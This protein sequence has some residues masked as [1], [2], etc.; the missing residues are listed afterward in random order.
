MRL[1]LRLSLF[2]LFIL[3]IVFAW[4]PWREHHRVFAGALAGSSSFQK[5]NPDS[6][7]Q[8]WNIQV[9]DSTDDV[10]QYTSLALDAVGNPHISYY[11]VTNQDLKY[12]RWSGD[13]WQIQ[14]VDST[15]NVGWYTSLALDSNS[16]PH[17]S[18]SDA[19]N[20]TL[21]YAYWT[22]SSWQIQTVDSVNGSTPTSLALDSS[23]RPHISYN[24]VSSFPS[25]NQL[26]YAVWTGSAW[27]LQTVDSNIGNL[28]SGS[29]IALDNSGNPH[30]SYEYSNFVQP[31]TFVRRLYYARW[32]GTSWQ[33]STVDSTGSVGDSCSI[34]VDSSGNP[35]ISY[36]DLSN[37][38]LK[39]ARWTG[40]SWLIQ[41]V[42]G[43]G[44]WPEGT[45]IAVDNGGTPHISFYDSE[46]SVLK[47]ARWTG[48]VWQIQTVDSVGNVGMYSSLTLD[49][50]GNP[51]IS[52][53]DSDNGDLK[54]ASL[55]APEFTPTP[56]PRPLDKFLN[57][58]LILK[59]YLP[60]AGGTPTPTQSVPTLSPTATPTRTSTQTP[61]S[62]ST[63]AQTFTPSVT[64]TYTPTPTIGTPP[65]CGIGNCDFEQGAV[66]W[67]E[68]SQNGLP[69]IIHAEELPIAPHSGS[70]AVWLGGDYD[71]IAYIQQT[72]LVPADR[73]YLSYWNWISS[74]D[75]PGYDYAYVFINGILVHNESLCSENNTSG[76]VQRVINLGA[77]AGQAVQLQVRVETD[78]SLNSS[79][80]LDD[81]AF[82]PSGN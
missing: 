59:N 38:N 61:T 42:S 14:T 60:P 62:T 44:N 24:L 1:T 9:V 11:D 80:F 45:S 31:S 28:G 73:Y 50:A 25:S 23:N 40:S 82:Q 79:Y 76:W 53:Y 54:Y 49:S 64:P 8:S 16:R 56:T 77:Y 58:P 48:S 33:T 17:I 5:G 69:L 26:K 74:E 3:F 36:V 70:W 18:Y 78:S 13:S 81:F 21:K 66:I 55:S 47:Y 46:N 63:L 6:L 72:V 22:G 19:T 20:K 39:Y 51:R 75:Y 41:V 43:V 7:L 2:F 67:T 37:T 32:T 52:Y 30:I 65:P 27:N 29:S 35:H 68:Y 15:G 10:G 4:A 12:A 71:E 57:I 34:D